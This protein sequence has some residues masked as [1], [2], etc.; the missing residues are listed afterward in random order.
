[1]EA[2]PTQTANVFYHRIFFKIPGDVTALLGAFL[3]P[4]LRALT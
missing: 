1:M 2:L 3:T 4:F